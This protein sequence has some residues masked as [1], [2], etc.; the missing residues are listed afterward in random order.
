[1]DEWSRN[2]LGAEQTTAG[3]SRP[4]ESTALTHDDASAQ[5]NNSFAF[6]MYS[7]LR[8][9]GRNLFFCPFSIRSALAMTYA[10]ARGQTA[11]EMETVL[12]FSASREMPH[13]AIGELIQRLNQSGGGNHEMRVANSCWSQRGA[14]IEREF[15]ELLIKHYATD[16]NV[17]DFRNSPE[18]VRKAINNWVDHETKS[19]IQDLIPSGGLT[20]D[21]RLVLANAVYL[22]A[23]WAARFATNDTREKPFHLETGKTV[24]AR[25][26]RQRVH[27]R[28]LD[29]NA[30]QAV[31]LN[32]SGAN[33]SM[34]VLLPRRRDGLQDIEM[35]LS[36]RFLHECLDQM[37]THRIDVLLPRFKFTWGTVNLHGCLA[38]LGIQQAFRPLQ[39]DFSGINGRK[40]RRKTHCSS[41]MF[42]TRVLS[43][44][45]R[46]ERKQRLPP[47]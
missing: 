35:H 24:S 41:P 5:G 2:L 34:I 1:M 38:H 47:R 13:V 25:L 11:T 8:R 39:A 27:V 46:K 22:K 26:M 33:L 42:F 43:K 30:Y 44:S 36:A 12:H 45:T 16:L 28:Y 19:R 10:G 15:V 23:A 4:P 14:P 32:Y 31:E 21:S 7:R 20:P 9:F 17:V 3:V 37:H 40:R 6:A 29:T 18:M